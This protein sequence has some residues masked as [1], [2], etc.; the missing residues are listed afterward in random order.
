M[1]T[2]FYAVVVKRREKYVHARSLIRFEYLTPTD[3]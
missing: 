3:G 1:E 2:N